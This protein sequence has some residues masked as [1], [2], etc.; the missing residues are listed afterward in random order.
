[1]DIFNIYNLDTGKIGCYNLTSDKI[2]GIS[3][4]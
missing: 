1:M 2:G 3:Y 4:G